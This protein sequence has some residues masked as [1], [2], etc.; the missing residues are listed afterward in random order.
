MR[1]GRKEKTHKLFFTYSKSY[2]DIIERFSSFTRAL[3]VVAIVIRAI[4]R[5]RRTGPSYSSS[6]EV[7]SGELDTA[8]MKLIS[9]AQKVAFGEEYHALENKKL[10]K[11]GHILNLNPFL[12]EKGIMRVGGRLANAVNL[13]YNERFYATRGVY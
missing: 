7:I 12:D 1:L 5:M 6:E 11:A 3:R 10:I 9:M 2:Y 4:Q 8:K 13:S